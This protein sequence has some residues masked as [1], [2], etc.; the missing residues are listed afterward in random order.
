MNI[1]CICQECG[2]EYIGET[3][4]ELKCKFCGSTNVE[5]EEW[6]V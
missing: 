4:Q 6:G 3:E 1:L 2:D 5:I